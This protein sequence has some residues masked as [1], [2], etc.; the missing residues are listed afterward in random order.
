MQQRNI[1]LYISCICTFLQTNK[2]N[3]ETNRQVQR[4]LLGHVGRLVGVADEPLLAIHQPRDVRD[5][6]EARRDYHG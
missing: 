3:K 4:N 1:Q 6:Q 5:H 2:W